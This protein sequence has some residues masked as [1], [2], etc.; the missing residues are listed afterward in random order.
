MMN[1]MLNFMN[2][3]IVGQGKDEYLILW[4]GYQKE[5]ASWVAAEDVT[6]AAIR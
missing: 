1:V 3:L 2:T 4:Q 5:E 6:S